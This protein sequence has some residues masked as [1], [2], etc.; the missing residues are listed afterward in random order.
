MLCWGETHT[1]T[2]W[3]EGSW[4]KLNSQLWVA[5]A[6]AGT[7]GPFHHWLDLKLELS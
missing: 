7:R 5:A 3:P 6:S 4:E 2:L 1:W